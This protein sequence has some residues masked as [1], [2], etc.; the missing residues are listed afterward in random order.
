MQPLGNLLGAYCAELWW[1]TRQAFAHGV[2]AAVEE[3][4]EQERLQADASFAMEEIKQLRRVLRRFPYW[5]RGHLRLGLL[6]LAARDVQTAYASAQAVL[7]LKPGRSGVLEA[8][9]L[10]ARCFLGLGEGARAVQ[11]LE[12]LLDCEPAARQKFGVIEDLA[13][14]CLLNGD[15]ARARELLSSLPPEHISPAAKAALHGL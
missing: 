13:A 7:Q 8:R 6:S 11:E 15:K 3:G 1:R 10:M 9:R 14:A 12:A 5:R 2:S 4:K